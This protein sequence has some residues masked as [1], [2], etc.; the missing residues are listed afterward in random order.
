M[1]EVEVVVGGVEVVAGSDAVMKGAALL[2]GARCKS[3][4]EVEV[5]G[6]ASGVAGEAGEAG[7]FTA[8]VT[9]GSPRQQRPWK[10]RWMPTL[11][12]K[13]RAPRAAWTR[14]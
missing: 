10:S 3:R 5:P 14:N 1:E 4:E 8:A 13:A 9:T 7:S 11:E 2:G 12:G 6:L